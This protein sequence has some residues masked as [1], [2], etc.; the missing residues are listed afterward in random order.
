MSPGGILLS[1]DR[2]ARVF[3]M[4]VSEADLPPGDLVD[5]IPMGTHEISQAVS[6]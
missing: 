2:L 6:R 5:G 3:Y 4:C 1:T